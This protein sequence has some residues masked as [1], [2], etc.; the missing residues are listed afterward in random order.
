MMMRFGTEI[1]AG[2]LVLVVQNGPPQATPGTAPLP[3]GPPIAGV[4]WTVVIPSFLFL[5]SFLGTYLLYKRFAKEE[6][7]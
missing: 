6:G 2:L 1:V 4:L 7:G 5:G 3:V